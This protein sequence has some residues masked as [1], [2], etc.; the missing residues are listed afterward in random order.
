MIGWVARRDGEGNAAS[1]QFER[2]RVKRGPCRR[3]APHAGHHAAREV[4]VA[5][6]QEAAHQRLVKAAA[7]G[8]PLYRV[9]SGLFSRHAALDRG[10]RAPPRRTINHQSKRRTDS[11]YRRM[12]DGEQVKRLKKAI[13]DLTLDKLILK[14]ALEGKY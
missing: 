7:A 13:S 12:K 14:E 9:A 2:H 11:T 6:D 8:G 10:L 4:A 5:A 3:R 1:L